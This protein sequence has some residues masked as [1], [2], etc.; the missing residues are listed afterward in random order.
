[1]E[2]TVTIRH[3]PGCHCAVCRRCI[4]VGKDRWL[5]PKRGSFGWNLNHSCSPSCC[6]HGSYIV[7]LRAIRKGDEIT[8]DY[9]TTNDDARWEMFCS[10]GCR[11]CRKTIRS[12]QRLP[13]RLLR[14]YAGRMP[15]YVEEK[16]R[17]DR[18]GK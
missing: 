6:I 18:T 7:A 13:A 12:I 15:R 5:Y 10:C 1:P 2:K 8:I 3:R 11:N 16:Y 9:S 17:A 4:Q 14:K